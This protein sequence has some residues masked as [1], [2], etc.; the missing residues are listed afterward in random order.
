MNYEKIK[1]HTRTQ[2]MTQNTKTHMLISRYYIKT[3]SY[4]YNNPNF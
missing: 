2:H 4:T 1:E 3:I